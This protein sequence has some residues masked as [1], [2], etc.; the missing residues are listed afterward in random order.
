MPA[1]LFPAPLWKQRGC[2][3]S[4][5][6]LTYLRGT[7]GAWPAAGW[8]SRERWAPSGAL[9]SQH[10][11]TSQA[12]T[13]PPIFL[14]DED[15]SQQLTTQ[16]SI[17]SCCRM[18]LSVK[19]MRCKQHTSHKIFYFCLNRQFT[20]WQQLTEPHGRINGMPDL[21]TVQAHLLPASSITEVS[22]PGFTPTCRAACSNPPC[23]HLTL[24]HTTEKNMACFS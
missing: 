2:K 12:C 19:M 1:Q 15:E 11:G 5:C 24:S 22:Q 9:T 16:S 13:L 14:L 6:Y 23:E 4:G 10:S 7:S 18:A 21:V 20:Q 17:Q 3:A 8:S